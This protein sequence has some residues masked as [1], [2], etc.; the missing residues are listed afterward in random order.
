[1]GPH[2]GCSPGAEAAPTPR[3]KGIPL[4]LPK[5]TVA[6]VSS[7]PTE[8]A[9]HLAER[10][11]RLDVSRREVA[12]LPEAAADGEPPQGA[13]P[14]GSRTDLQESPSRKVVDHGGSTDIDALSEG[15][16]REDRPPKGAVFRVT[17][18]GTPAVRLVE[19]WTGAPRLDRFE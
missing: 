8:P 10:V 14:K 3:I 11:N 6:N 17:P 4:E 5:F 9:T 18:G 12:T 19:A 1:V 16:R 13:S 15:E 2:A 7:G